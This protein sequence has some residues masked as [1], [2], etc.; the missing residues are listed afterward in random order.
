MWSFETHRAMNLLAA[1]GALFVGQSVRWPGTAMFDSLQGIE[2]ETRIE[3]PVAEELQLGF[4]TGLALQGFLVVSIFPRMD[5]LMRA[6]DQLVNHLDKL[7]EMS[8][9]Q[10][11]PKV[12]IRTRVGGK[13]PL[14]AGPQHTQD[15]TRALR[16]MLTTVKVARVSSEDEVMPTYRRA[17]ERPE[18][19][20]V[21]EAV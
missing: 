19:T 18:S 10:F 6:M 16:M 15:H 9:G 17:L 13:T 14:D 7:A 8:R 20:V 1:R 21:V 4:C 11:N 2:M 3:F 12:I 5:F